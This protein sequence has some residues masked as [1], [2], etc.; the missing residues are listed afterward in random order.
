MGMTLN[1]A[2]GSVAERAVLALAIL[3]LVLE[4]F[5]DDV[6]CNKPAPITHQECVEVCQ[7]YLIERYERWVCQCWI[8][9][10]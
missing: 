8:P 2:G 4:T 9:K 6:T 3:G 1:L 10:E 7:P 5:A